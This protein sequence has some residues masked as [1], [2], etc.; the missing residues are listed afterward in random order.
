VALVLRIDHDG[1]SINEFIQE[2]RDGCVFS[3]IPFDYRPH[4]VKLAINT[5]AKRQDVESILRSEKIEFVSGAAHGQYDAF[6]G[7]DECPIFY[8]GQDLSFLKGAIVH[9]LSCRSGAVLGRMIVAH[10]ARAFWGYTT[11]FAYVGVEGAKYEENELIAELFLRMDFVIDRGIL[12]GRSAGVIYQEVARYVI[13]ALPSLS[14]FERMLMIDNFMHLVCPITT[15][16]DDAAI[17]V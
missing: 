3:R 10:G 7:H 6:L 17:L 1:D 16:G 14:R 8:A 4:S 5:S 9:L 13:G 12:A 15:W 2:L 11:D